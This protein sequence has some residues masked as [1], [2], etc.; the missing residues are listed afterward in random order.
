MSQMKTKEDWQIL[1]KVMQALNHA[2]KIDPATWAM[3]IRKAGEDRSMGAVF[4]MARRPADHGLK[5]DSHE[6]AQKFMTGVV[7]GVAAAGWTEHAAARGLRDAE[8]V[9]VLLNDEA[10]RPRSGH[11][12]RMSRDPAFLAV[13]MTM[14]AV[15]ARTH[16]KAAQYGPRLGE[17]IDVLLATWPEDA[18]LLSVYPD[19]EYLKGGGV[20][21]L[22]QKSQCLVALAPIIKGFELAQHAV[23]SGPAA[24]IASRL[25][26][27]YEERDSA[28]NSLVA[29]EQQGKINYS[30]TAGGKMMELCFPKEK[31]KKRTTA[32]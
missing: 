23:G 22:M 16:V 29:Q 30:L 28:V 4:D 10:H 24:S 11:W 19:A 12:V 21:Y 20:H 18:G 5:L 7:R 32:A 14:A 8:R 25:A 3:L 26:R 13:A 9:L 1:P 31:K 6:K 27:L 15:L 17:Y 2:R